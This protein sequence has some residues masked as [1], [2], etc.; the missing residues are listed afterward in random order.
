MLGKEID[1]LER[2]V[3][4]GALFSQWR[5]HGGDDQRPFDVANLFWAGMLAAQQLPLEG[6]L[7][8]RLTKVPAGD[9]TICSDGGLDRD[10]AFAF[11]F[12]RCRAAADAADLL[13]SEAE[14]LF[15]AGMVASAALGVPPR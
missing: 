13:P 11:W 4:F 7:P 12:A 1:V 5:R 15:F 9:G 6:D 14:A 3:A 8:A 10:E 2:D